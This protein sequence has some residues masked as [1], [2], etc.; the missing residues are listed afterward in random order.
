MGKWLESVTMNIPYT[1]PYTNY[2]MIMMVKDGIK[3]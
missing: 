2:M 3:S 1:R